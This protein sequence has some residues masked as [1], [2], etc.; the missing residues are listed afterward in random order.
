MTANQKQLQVQLNEDISEKTIFSHS[1]SLYE[2][3]K[4]AVAKLDILAT[5]KTELTDEFILVASL[6]AEEIDH[7]LAMCRA[8]ESDE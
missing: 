8:F 6:T 7:D 3:N 4:D 5:T 2:P 1:I